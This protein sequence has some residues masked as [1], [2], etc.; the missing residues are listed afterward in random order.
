MHPMENRLQRGFTV[1]ELM[2]TVTIVAI[3]AAVAAPSFMG[4]INTN[5]LA[6]QSNELLSAIQY[7]RTEAVRLNGRVTF[8]GTDN[9]NAD[10]DDDCSEGQHPFWV[11]IGPTS[12]GGQ[13]QLRILS[14]PDSVFVSTNLKM[15][16][17]GADGLAREGATLTS[18]EISVC[19][20]TNNP[21]DNKRLLTIASGSRV[22]VSKPE[23]DGE[24]SCE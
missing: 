18:G 9:E 6:A 2:V 4:M 11:V 24:G 7:A 10:G 14:V 17:F 8:C 19:M 15:V 1:V 16:T 5:R 21:P 20:K 23:G 22:T 13:E 12:G 3:L